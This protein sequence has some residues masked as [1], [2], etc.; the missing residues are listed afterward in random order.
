M[1]TA[2]KSKIKT[3]VNCHKDS[4]KLLKECL[5]R[6]SVKIDDAVSIGEYHTTVI[7][8]EEHS[9]AIMDLVESLGYDTNLSGNNVLTIRWY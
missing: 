1:Q 6:I 9:Q 8:S 5:K 7:I 4:L 3:A 2:Q